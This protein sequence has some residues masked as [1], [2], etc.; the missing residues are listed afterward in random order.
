MRPVP[1]S[2]EEFC[3][4]WERVCSDELEIN[5]A[6]LDIFSIR[7]PKPWFV[8]MPT[9]VWDQIFRPMVA[10]QRWIAAGMAPRCRLRTR[11]PLGSCG[12]WVQRARISRIVETCMRPESV[13]PGHKPCTANARPEVPSRYA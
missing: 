11:K 5:R 1:K 4:Y 7:I 8:L 13:Q 3:E 12:W 2:W 10:G 6:T 9:P